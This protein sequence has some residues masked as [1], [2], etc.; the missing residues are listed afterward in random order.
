[1]SPL[2]DHYNPYEA[3]A[4]RKY[5]HESGTSNLVS[6]SQIMNL[7]FV[8]VVEVSIAAPPAMRLP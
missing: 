1:M 7:H 4:V 8:T 3:A 6:A 5:K 2:T